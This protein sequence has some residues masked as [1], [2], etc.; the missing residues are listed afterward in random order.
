MGLQKKLNRNDSRFKYEFPNAYFKII[1]VDVNTLTDEVKILVRAYADKEARDFDVSGEGLP[2]LNTSCKLF[3][4]VYKV[5]LVVASDNNETNPK[6]KLLKAAYT[7]L[8]SYSGHFSDA[9][10][11]L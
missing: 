3:D 1:K 6:D 8:K 11:I 2:F 5:N 9:I 7:W 10:D 4:N